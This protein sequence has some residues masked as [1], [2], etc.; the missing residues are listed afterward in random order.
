MHLNQEEHLLAYTKIPA[1]YL[2][3]FQETLRMQGSQWLKGKQSNPK[4]ELQPSNPV[5]F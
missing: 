1:V 4:A 5:E 2:Y 3:R